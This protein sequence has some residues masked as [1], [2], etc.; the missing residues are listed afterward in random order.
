MSPPTIRFAID[1]STN[2]FG[3]SPKT[4]KRSPP[5]S[6]RTIQHSVSNS[7]LGQQQNSKLIFDTS[8]IRSK[9]KLTDIDSKYY[10]FDFD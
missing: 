4:R 7:S 10:L 3:L 6:L 9:Q 1:T 5:L 2:P 8:P